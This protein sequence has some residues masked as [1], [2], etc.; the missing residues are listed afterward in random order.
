MTLEPR[1]G[2]LGELQLL[3]LDIL[4][5]LD[6]GTVYDVMGALPEDRPRRYTTILTVLRSLEKRGLVTHR[7]EGRAYVFRMAVPPREARRGM[8]R[9][10]MARVFAGSPTQLVAAL[11]DTEEATPDVLDQIRMM[12]AERG[13]KDREDRVRS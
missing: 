2:D 11:L 7:E 1:T 3:V 4:S 6:E 13:A 8:L 12:I 9:E 5:R 10:L